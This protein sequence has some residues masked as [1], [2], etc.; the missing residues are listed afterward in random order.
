[1]SLAAVR[2]SYHRCGIC[3][4]ICAGAL[5]RLRRGHRCGRL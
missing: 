4:G 5:A 1:M 2:Q 3:A